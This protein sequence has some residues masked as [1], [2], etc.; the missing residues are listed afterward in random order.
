MWDFQYAPFKTFY[1]LRFTFHVRQGL[2]RSAL[3]LNH[4]IAVD[5]IQGFIY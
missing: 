4:R 1:P 3:S 2:P 5:E